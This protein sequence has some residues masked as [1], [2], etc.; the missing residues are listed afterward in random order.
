M[1]TKN[2]THLVHYMAVDPS[3]FGGFS[4]GEFDATLP[5]GWTPANKDW[6]KAEIRKNNPGKAVVITAVTEYRR[7]VDI[8]A[9]ALTLTTLAGRLDTAAAGPDAL[10]NDRVREVSRM[11]AE[12]VE[13][14]S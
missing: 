4:Y 5:A 8:S 7:A 11:L 2:S 3:G 10:I 14:L 9:L 6:C 12:V 13:K 1:A